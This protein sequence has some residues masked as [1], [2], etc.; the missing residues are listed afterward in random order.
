MSDKPRGLL[1]LLFALWGVQPVR[2]DHSHIDPANWFTLREG[3]DLVVTCAICGGF[4]GR[5]PVELV[6]EPHGG[7]EFVALV[8]QM[9]IAQRDYFRCRTPELLDQAKRL[10]AE[11]D[12]RLIDLPANNKQPTLF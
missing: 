12:Q 9:R 1:G 6:S 8:A 11:V 10:E 3:Q 7:A 5:R 2:R 4:I